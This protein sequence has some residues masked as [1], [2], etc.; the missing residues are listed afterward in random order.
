MGM[1]SQTNQVKKMDGRCRNT[2]VGVIHHPIITQVKANLLEPNVLSVRVASYYDEENLQFLK[3]KGHA[4]ITKTYT[5]GLPQQKSSIP[6]FPNICQKM[7][8][9][10]V[11]FM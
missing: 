3:P 8:L 11:S 4:I 9:K 1:D 6:R 7:K 2:L 10:L 5:T